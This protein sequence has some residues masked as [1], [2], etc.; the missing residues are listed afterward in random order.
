MDS[1]KKQNK[2]KIRVLIVNRPDMFTLPGGDTTHIM[3]LKAGLE[4]HNVHVD[5]VADVFPEQNNYDV[6]N[7]FNLLIPQHTLRQVLSLRANSFTPIILTPLYWDRSESIWGEAAV[8]LAVE[9]ANNTQELD[10]LLCQISAGTFI[11]GK[12]SRDGN[13][14]PYADYDIEQKEALQFVDHVI[15]ISDKEKFVLT[16]KLG[17]PESKCTTIKIGN[18]LPKKKANPDLFIK[19]Y[20]IKDFVIVTGRVETRKNQLMLLCALR[21]S[22]IPIVVSGGQPDKNYLELCKKIAPPN[23]FFVG[24][25][26]DEMLA[27]ARAAARVHALPSW[28]ECAGI[29]HMEGSIDGCNIVVGNKAAEPEYFI[30]G[31]YYCDPADVN[32]VRKAVLSAYNNYDKD[33]DRIEK[34]QKHIRTFYDWD[35]VAEKNLETFKEVATRY[36]SANSEVLEKRKIEQKLA[37]AYSTFLKGEVIETVHMLPSLIDSSSEN[38]IPYGL[39][40]KCFMAAFI[41]DKAIKMFIQALQYDSGNTQLIRSL[42]Q[43]LLA[44]GQVDDAKDIL[45]KVLLLSPDDNEARWLLSRAYFANRDLKKSLEILQGKN[46]E[47]KKNNSATIVVLTYNSSKT[48]SDCLQSVSANLRD[49][50]EVIVV[51]NASTDST[52]KFVRQFITGRDKFKF[53]QNGKNIGFSAG[54]NV[55]IRAGKNPIV[56]LLN[57]DTVVTTNW[58]NSITAHLQNNN[59]GAVGP[60]SNYVAGYQKMELYLQKEL[61][62]EISSDAV[63]E[64]FYNQNKGKSVETK[65]LIGFCL[66]VRRNVLEEL[67][68]LDEN[69]FLGNDDLELSW[70]LRTNGYLLKVALDTF[71][72]HKGQHSF[73]TVPKPVTKKLVQESTD[74]L[75]L[76]LQNYYGL[77]EVPSPIELWGMDWF[78]PTNGVFKSSVQDFPLIDMSGEINNSSE[79]YRKRVSIIALTYNGLEYT[80]QF[81]ESLLSSGTSDYELILIDNAS[82]DKTPGYLLE[83]ADQN[84]NVKVILNKENLGFPAAVNQGLLAAN[85]KDI[86][87]ANNDI[88]FTNG[89]LN[90]MIEIADSDSAIG[91]VGPISNEVS[92]LQIDKNAKY[93]SINEMHSYASKIGN[94]NKNETLNFPRLAFLCTFIKRELIE[95]IG[96]LDERFT[97]GNYEDDDYCLRAQLAGYKAMIAKDVF[98]HHHGS[99][100]FKADGNE[101]YSERLQINKQKFIE[102]WGVTPD[103]LWIQKKEINSH[104]IF[105]PINNNKFDEQFERAR[106]LIADK[107]LEPALESL[108][109]ALGFYN[110][111]EQKKYQVDYSDLLDLAGNIALATQNIELAQKYFEEELQLVPES[112]SA[113]AGL[114]EIFFINGQYDGAK[115]LF[116]WAVKNNEMNNS[117]V[118]SLT[119]VNSILGLEPLHNS[120]Y[121]EE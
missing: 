30:D 118:D 1:K 71:V 86:V 37:M 95:K 65:L 9:K 98:I 101:K 69:L 29:S 2:K 18:E 112:S 74:A 48:I 63:A 116:E 20:G 14:R 22:N 106:I 77:N 78:T 45:E 46:L 42:G 10:E 107:E 82:S 26:D 115:A 100:S 31:A 55:G 119:K 72:Y 83:L 120:L 8:S 54:T 96:G 68:L 85:G 111:V 105:F 6:I 28:W 67:G 39:A 59:V 27:S 114:G 99:K 93:K 43:A 38:A 16:N 19:K 64:M 76:K 102:K 58:L 23:T 41:P 109:L 87:I 33:V 80:K 88:V 60:L 17:F 47:I 3:M 5:V 62:A 110:K 56:I 57:P 53:I 61:P 35:L 24:R 90:R 40:G 70:R 4:K 73:N 103:E 79:L 36:D 81:Y 13:N 66:A 50:D 117:A 12:Y 44:V 91:L 7:I 11:A 21:N 32:S 34:L 15:T 97:P 113:C 108:Q 25:L 52:E 84:V 89:W 121:Q 104:Q 51:D 94:E 75:Y 92:G 49:G